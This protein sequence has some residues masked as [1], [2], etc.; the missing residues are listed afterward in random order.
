M[1]TK[2]KEYLGYVAIGVAF[3]GWQLYIC[4]RNAISVERGTK[5]ALAEYELEKKLEK[6]AML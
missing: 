1:W 5:A 3:A 4:E 6:G 2:I